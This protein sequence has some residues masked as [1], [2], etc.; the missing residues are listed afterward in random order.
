VVL[1]K[2]MQVELEGVGMLGLEIQGTG[3][4]GVQKVV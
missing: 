2:F 1:V 4:E 3:E